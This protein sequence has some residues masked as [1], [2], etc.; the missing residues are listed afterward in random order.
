M[1][2]LGQVEYPTRDVDRRRLLGAMF[3]L[4][5]SAVNKFTCEELEE[6]AIKRGY[7][8]KE[9]EPEAKKE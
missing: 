3:N 7:I 6:I 9:P 1:K 2:G 8:H 5:N 4:S